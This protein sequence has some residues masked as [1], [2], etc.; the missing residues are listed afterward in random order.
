MEVCVESPESAQNA[1]K[2]G[3]SR[4][5]L[6]ANL[7]EGGTTPSVGMLRVIKNL[8][9]IPVFVMI[10][11]RGGDFCYTSVELQIMKEDIMS[12]KKAGADGFVFGI[13]TSDGEVDEN[14]STELLEVCFPLSA[15]FH[16]AIDMSRDV[17]GSLA[18]IIKLGFSR[19]LSSGGCQTALQGAEVLKAMVCQAQDKIIIMPGGGLTQ[20]N[21]AEVL[22]I[23]KAREFHGSARK[24]V[25]SVMTFMNPEVSMGAETNCEYIRKV[26]SA[27]LV[28]CFLKIAHTQRDI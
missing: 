2:G 23:T 19:V 20:E 10:R 12:L 28:S 4:V 1:E 14:K 26:T 27:E 7:L 11:P 16:R 17:S 25:K 6:C 18:K 24:P 8:V 9:S 22:H 15:T 5:E 13:L 21:L 3:A